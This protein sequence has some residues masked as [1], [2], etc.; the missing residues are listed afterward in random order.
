MP[1]ALRVSNA[2]GGGDA[3]TVAGG[4]SVRSEAGSRVA[5]E[6]V[7]AGEHVDGR[8][9]RGQARRGVILDAA[10]QCVSRDG[11]GALTH[12][13]AAGKAGVSLASVTYHFP[14]IEDLLDAT[15]VVCL[16]HMLAN[17]KATLAD[18]EGGADAVDACVALVV[19]QIGDDREHTAALSEMIYWAARR[20]DKAA[21]VR[22]WRRSLVDLMVGSGRDEP[23]AQVVS[24]AIRGLVSDA[25]LSPVAPTR[26]EL[27]PQMRLILHL[28]G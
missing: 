3:S 27:M 21:L 15:L 7:N 20:Q 26:D 19:R 12:R 24:H 6:Q 16:D 1:S 17:Q 4:V 18:I 25:L 14:S 23:K 9:S 5:V 13:A 8:R 28:F 2:R 11:V 10:V 22:R